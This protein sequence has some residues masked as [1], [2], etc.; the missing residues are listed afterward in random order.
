MIKNTILF[1]TAIIFSNFSSIL[2]SM[3]QNSTNQTNLEII[4]KIHNVEIIEF[5]DCIDGEP[6][7]FFQYE[8]QAVSSNQ[9]RCITF[10]HQ[11]EIAR[12]ISVKNAEELN[13]RNNIHKNQFMGNNKKK[14]KIIR[15]GRRK[16]GIELSNII[17]ND[18]KRKRKE[19]S[20]LNVYQLP[21]EVEKIISVNGQQ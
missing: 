18:S 1:L 7:V 13:T 16:H 14:R 20:L 2:L 9:L 19:S 17:S 11:L 12:E 5:D 8:K 6:V 10:A 21:T 3:E 15:R 4:R